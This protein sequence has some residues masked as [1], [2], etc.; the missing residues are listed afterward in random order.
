VVAL[1]GTPDGIAD[2]RVARGES[3][4][5]FAVLRSLT[6]GCLAFNKHLTP[7]LTE[8]AVTSREEYGPTPAHLPHERGTDGPRVIMVGVNG[9]TAALRAAAYAGGLA[10]RQHARLVVVFVACVPAWTSLAA[11][12]L[13]AQEETLRE[14]ADEVRETVRDRADEL[15]MSI[16]FLS[17]R[18]DPS[19]QLARAAD[20]VRADLVVVGSSRR[21]GRHLLGGV[22][23]KLVRAGRWPVM[24]VP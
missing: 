12:A 10:R 7:Q 2:P 5:D 9:T 15:G 8:A 19:T 17:L 20:E 4:V 11:A 18:G 24:V 3:N 21:I 1:I 16:T 13:A 23:R 14:L 6:P 22:A